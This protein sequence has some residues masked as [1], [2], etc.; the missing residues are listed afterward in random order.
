MA[1]NIKEQD[2]IEVPE[3]FPIDP[4]EQELLELRVALQ[5][6]EKFLERLHKRLVRIRKKI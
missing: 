1:N 3:P 4:K 6:T 2:L 5:K